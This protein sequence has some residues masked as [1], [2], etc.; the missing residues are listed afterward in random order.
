MLHETGSFPAMGA[1]VVVGGAS[2]AELASIA[3]LFEEWERVFSRFRPDSELN[4]VNRA[5]GVV[6]AVSPL[7]AR[8]LETALAAAAA[9]EGLVDPTLGVAIEAAGYDRDFARVENDGGPLARTA[10]GRWRALRLVGP[11]LWRPPGTSLDLNGVVKALA[12]DEALDLLARDGFVSAGGDVAVRGGAV[13]G[14]PGG[15]S[16]AATIGGLATSGTRHRRWVRGDRVQHHLID[17][18]TGRPAASRWTEVTVG[19][20][21]CLAADIGAKAAFL[22][23]D[24]GPSWLDERGLPGRFLDGGQVIT[25]QAWRAADPGVAAC[26]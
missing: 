25:N 7:F 14:L 11:I 16:V 8:V 15:G 4:A 2:P 19:A 26:R 3:R 20:G 10:R 9:T 6:V 22:L 13:V 23:S 17:P 21:S 18:R 12:V 24:D 5:S 1:E